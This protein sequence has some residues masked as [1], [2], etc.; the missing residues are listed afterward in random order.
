MN[1]VI[2]IRHNEPEDKMVFPAARSMKNKN[3]R[4]EKI[5]LRCYAAPVILITDRTNVW[6]VSPPKS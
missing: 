4:Y 3:Y 6:D 1:T 5:N 2:V